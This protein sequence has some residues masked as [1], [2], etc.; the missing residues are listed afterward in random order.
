VLGL[1]LGRLAPTAPTAS[2]PD[3]GGGPVPQVAQP[4]PEPTS[5]PEPVPL[6][7]HAPTEIAA[8]VT[9]AALA[10][11]TPDLLATADV[12][13]VRDAS[14]VSGGPRAPGAPGAP[15]LA[16]GAV[17][18]SSPGQPWWRYRRVDVPLGAV[19]EGVPNGA[20]N[21]V[22]N[23]AALPPVKGP[24]PVGQPPASPGPAAD[25]GPVQLA[26][27]TTRSGVGFFALGAVTVAVV[28]GL[29]QAGTNGE[30]PFLVPV[31]GLFFA[32]AAAR[33][34]ARTRPA[35]A[36]VGNWLVWGLVAKL[37][38]AYFRYYTLIHTYNGLGDA[39]DYDNIGRQY[40]SHW[41]NGTPGPRL[42]SPGLRKTN[43]VR[44]FTGVT[45][46]SFGSKLLTGTFVFALLALVGSYF[47]YR[48]TVDAVPFIDR[49]LYLA[50]VLFAPSIVFWPSIVGKEAL[51]QFGLG[52]VAFGASLLVRQRLATGLVVAAAG[53]WLVWVVRPHL[54][55]LVAIAAGAA[56]LAGRVRKQTG[57]AGLLTR[58]IGI[59]VIAFLVAFTVGQGAQF[60][61]IS[62]LSLSSIQAELNATTAST[63]QGGSHFSHGNNSLSPL[64]WPMDAVTVFL[65]PFPWEVESSLQILASLESM[66]LAALIVW[67]FKSLRAALARSR[68]APFLMLCWVL[69]G[70]Y[71]VSF[72]SFANFGLL[73]RERSLVLP[74]LFVL[75]SVDPIRA[76][77][78]E[79]PPPL[80]SADLAERPVITRV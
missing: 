76:R 64:A 58:P 29:S 33:R 62:S 75:L 47:W 48:A 32:L 15:S 26:S 3:V 80:T 66:A 6:Q 54:L 56:Y 52:V 51:M 8:V 38:A 34:I 31:A 79:L 69:T 9:A 20:H 78:Q 25:A 74:A 16:V 44:W 53:G 55:A 35:E 77:L 71:A 5:I 59:I 42:F 57:K 27:T 60:L 22:T 37:L 4:R 17:D 72:A 70:L 28:A 36:W 39:A 45:Y 30:G 19:V 1:A 7:S 41:L 67:R 73:V 61:G 65:R 24:P 23:G 46:Y 63:S 21:G 18:P 49:R 14:D 68:E 43:F 12:S 10:R 50:F 40:A 13:N 2:D 11:A